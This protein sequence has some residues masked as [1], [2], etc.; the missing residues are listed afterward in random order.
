MMIKKV[1]QHAEEPSI[2]SEGS[3]FFDIKA[4]LDEGDRLSCYNSLNKETKVPVKKF[5]NIPGIQIYPQQRFLIPTG[6]N[7][8]VP[9]GYIIK[10]FSNYDTSL[11]KG[12]NLINAVQVIEPGDDTHLEIA[13]TSSTDAVSLLRNGDVIASGCIEKTFHFVDVKPIDDENT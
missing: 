2:P 3:I 9:E 1:K 12:I 5:N 7:F 8:D 11:K 13:L 4:C 10:L 6:L